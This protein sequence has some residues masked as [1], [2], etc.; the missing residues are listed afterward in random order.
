[1]AREK[2]GT[3]VRE[4]TPEQYEELQKAMDEGRVL[5]DPSPEEWERIQKL[6][7]GKKSLFFDS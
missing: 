2:L 1:M 7:E 5:I 4:M 3:Y 6:V